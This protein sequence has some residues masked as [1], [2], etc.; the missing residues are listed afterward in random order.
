MLNTRSKVTRLLTCCGDSAVQPLPAGTGPSPT[1]R[2]QSSTK[3][4]LKMKTP[5]LP[6][7]M[8]RAGFPEEA[9]I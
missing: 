3:L 2:W 7:D 9:G 5:G 1:P 4:P 6:V 8:V